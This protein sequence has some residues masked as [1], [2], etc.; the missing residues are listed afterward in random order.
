MSFFDIPDIRKVFNRFLSTTQ[1]QPAYKSRFYAYRIDELR[2]LT[3]NAPGGP[4]KD[5][6][7]ALITELGALAHWHPIKAWISRRD[8][9][10]RLQ[11]VVNQLIAGKRPV[12][13]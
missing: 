4:P 9:Q 7:E 5:N 3:K 11:D 8:I 6:A 1:S 10:T 13:P 2:T 12:R